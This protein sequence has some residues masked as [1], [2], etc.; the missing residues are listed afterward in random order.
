MQNLSD[1]LNHFSEPGRPYDV[2][3]WAVPDF[4][5]NAPW[6]QYGQHTV[7][8]GNCLLNHPAVIGGPR[9]KRHARTP[10]K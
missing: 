7:A 2:A 8:T 6:R 9:N 1:A 10:K 4:P 5:L 3:R